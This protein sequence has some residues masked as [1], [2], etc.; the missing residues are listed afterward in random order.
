MRSPVRLFVEG[1]PVRASYRA[2]WGIAMI[3]VAG[4]ALALTWSAVSAPLASVI[5]PGATLDQSNPYRPPAC[6][7]KGWRGPYPT[8]W[9]A[10]TFT[11]GLTGTLTDVVLSLWGNTTPI[12]VAIAPVDGN[13]QPL[14]ATPLA[15][16]SFAFTTVTTPTNIE[17]PFSVPAKV[18]AGKQ[19]AIVL[20]APNENAPSSSEDG[21]FVAW[22]A[23]DGSSIKDPRGTPCADGAYAAGRAWGLDTG[24]TPDVVGGD[25]DLFFQ[26]YV[27]APPPV[28]TPRP[29]RLSISV[30]VRGKGRVSGGGISCPARCKATIAAGAKLTLRATPARGYRFAGWAGACSG[31]RACTLHPTAAIKVTAAFRKRR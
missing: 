9:Y 21:V 22:A 19:Y 28:T 3:A 27:L 15:S 14:V 25:S 23:D 1:D 7:F 18:E 2:R 6:T 10:Q 20:S 5:A 16:T 17:I 13:G 29:R 30:T 4:L 31:L 11:A 12:T 26:T 8:S 24:S